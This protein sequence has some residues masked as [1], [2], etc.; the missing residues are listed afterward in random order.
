MGEILRAADLWKIYPMGDT[1]VSAL[2]G[3]SL[4]IS[5]GEI[6]AITG[7]SGSGKT[8]LLNCLSS[9]DT[10]SRGE[11]YFEERDISNISDNERTKLRGERMGFIFQQYQLIPVLNAVENVELP[12]LLL[13]FPADEAR[14]KA[15][16]S[17]SML[18][19]SN[20]S[21]HKPSELSG[22]QQQRVAIARAIVH[23]P[24]ILFADEPTG[25]L[26]S[27][28]SDSVIQA[29]EE[30]N[31]IHGITIVIVTHDTSVSQRCNR[32]LEINDGILFEI[33]K[34]EE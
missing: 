30:L 22:G 1:E 29:L 4:E 2:R 21:N 27:D 24:K 31:R 17:L 19:L 13:N 15:L 7:P 34:E 14:K 33:N 26:D 12:L 20:R 6:L 5:Q 3:V 10:V 28:T 8:T 23:N 25:N 18:G 32:I 9:L 11:I 16:E